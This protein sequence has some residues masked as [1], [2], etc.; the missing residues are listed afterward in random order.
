MDVMAKLLNQMKKKFEAFTWTSTAPPKF[1]FQ[2]KENN[3][4]CA[5]NCKF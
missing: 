4:Y 1:L 5:T 3:Q 2:E